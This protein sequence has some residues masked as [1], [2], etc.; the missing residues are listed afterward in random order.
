MASRAFSFDIP[1]PLTDSDANGGSS[2][3]RRLYTE[4]RNR[5]PT[6]SGVP[7]E[8]LYNKIIDK[9]YPTGFNNREIKFDRGFARQTQQKVLLAAFG[10]GYEQRVKD[11]INTKRETYT[12]N[13]SNRLW[14]EITLISLFFDIVQPASFLI[15]LERESVRVAVQSYSVNIGHD[16]VQSI[17]AQLRRVYTV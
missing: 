3:Q 7:D 11:G 8:E 15:R 12:M 14:Q 4:L 2:L 6:E 1:K 10:D 9:L 13:L 17:S 5:Y 16:D